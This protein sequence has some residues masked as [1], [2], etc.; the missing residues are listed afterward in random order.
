[1]GNMEQK[2]NKQINGTQVKKGKR[3]LPQD[4]SKSCYNCRFIRRLRFPMSPHPTWHVKQMQMRKRQII[5]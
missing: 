5:L 1:M 4:R 3:K 2:K